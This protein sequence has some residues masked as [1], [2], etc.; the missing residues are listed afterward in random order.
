MKK[1]SAFRSEYLI[2][3]RSLLD[4][5]VLPDTDRLG[6]EAR[7]AIRELIEEIARPFSPKGT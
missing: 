3:L 6:P 1:E 4:T 5:H 7:L 2:P